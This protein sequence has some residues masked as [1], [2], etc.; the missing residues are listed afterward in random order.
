MH[1]M[2]Y[3]AFKSVCYKHPLI[4]SIFM[5]ISSSDY[6]WPHTTDLLPLDR[7]TGKFSVA[8]FLNK[9]GPWTNHRAASIFKKKSHNPRLLSSCASYPRCCIFSVNIFF[10]LSLGGGVWSS[11]WNAILLFCCWLYYQLPMLKKWALWPLCLGDICNDLQ[12]GGVE[13]VVSLHLPQRRPRHSVWDNLQS[14][15]NNFTL[16]LRPTSRNFTK[17]PTIKTS[18]SSVGLLVVES[19]PSPRPFV[20]YTLAQISMSMNSVRMFFFRHNTL[21]TRPKLLNSWTRRKILTAFFPLMTSMLQSNGWSVTI[22]QWLLTRHTA[23]LK[24]PTTRKEKRFTLRFWNTTSTS[25][26]C[27]LRH[28]QKR[29]RKKTLCNTAR[30][31]CLKSFS[32]SGKSTLGKLRL[33]SNGAR[34]TCQPTPHVL[35]S[36]SQE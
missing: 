27:F 7:N 19:R 9:T 31:R 13:Q 11:D 28:L 22:L 3:K 35:L 21:K 10:Q 15:A 36:R 32:G 26:D 18:S 33:S 29:W 34:S 5:D 2:F 6:H 17:R 8:C 1:N 23:S 12:F 25:L 16:K 14:P 30:Q 4:H 24:L 20:D